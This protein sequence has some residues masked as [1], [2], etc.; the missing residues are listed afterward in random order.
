[1]PPA[2]GLEVDE[3]AG[4]GFQPI[5]D[6]AVPD[7]IDVPVVG[8]DQTEGP[9]RICLIGLP[10]QAERERAVLSESDIDQPGVG[11][12]HPQG[13]MVERG[14]ERGTAPDPSR[15][16]GDLV[17]EGGE[18]LGEHAV[19]FVAE[20]P[21][22]TP[23]DLVGQVRGHQTDRLRQVDAQ[24]LERHGAKM[25]QVKTAQ[26]LGVGHLGSFDTE[27]VKVA[28]DVRGVQG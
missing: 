22:T 19:E 1:M 2:H 7:D 28:I 4:T 20:A 17:A 23:Q 21:A 8:G 15:Q 16:Q 11:A 9:V 5:L 12:V 13:Q 18:Q 6:D 24:V 25:R 26:L 27:P 3:G 14:P 10:I